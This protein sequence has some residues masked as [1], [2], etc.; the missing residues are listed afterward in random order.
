M[1]A[2]VYY[3]ALD[4]FKFKFTFAFYR[5]CRGI[6]MP[7]WPVNIRCLDKS[8]NQSMGRLSTSTRVIT[9]VTPVCP[10]S[11]SCGSSSNQAFSS[12][13]VE[14]HEYTMIIDFNS[15]TLKKFLTNGCCWVRVETSQ[16]AR[17]GAI[18]TGPSGTMYTYADINICRAPLNTSPQFDKEPIAYLCCNQPARFTMGGGDYVDGDHCEYSWANPMRGYNQNTSYSSKYSYREPFQ[19]HYPGSLK[20]PYSNPVAS[21]PVG[22]FLDS[23]SG[24][25]VFTPTKCDEVTVAV[26]EIREYRTNSSG[27]RELIGRTRRDM[28]FEITQCPANAPPR[29]VGKTTHTFTPSVCDSI[30]TFYIKTEDKPVSS[31]KKDTVSVSILKAPPGTTIELVDSTSRTPEVKVTWKP[32]KSD[33]VKRNEVQFVLKAK[34]QACPYFA[35]T[36]KTFRLIL[37]EDTVTTKVRIKAFKDGDKDCVLDSGETGIEGRNIQGRLVSQSSSPVLKYK[38]DTSGLMELCTNKGKYRVT[39]FPHPY[40]YDLCSDT[41][42]TAEVDSTHFV[43]FG[44]EELPNTVN[45]KVFY[46]DSSN[47]KADSI[48][49]GLKWTLVKATPGPYYG[50]SDYNGNYWINL[51]NGTF[52]LNPSKEW[53]RNTCKSE[54]K[55][56]LKND[57]V[58]KNANLFVKQDTGN[59]KLRIDCPHFVRTNGKTLVDLVAINQGPDTLKDVKAYMYVRS[60]LDGSNFYNFTKEN[61][62]LFSISGDIPPHSVI[63]GRL[64]INLSSQKFSSGDKFTIMGAVKSTHSLLENIDN[65]DDTTSRKIEV[66]GSYDPNIKVTIQD[67]LITPFDSILDY[68]IHFQNTGTAPAYYVE[69][70]DTLPDELDLGELNIE[71]ASH[72]PVHP[73]LRDNKLFFIFDEIV[74]P[75][76]SSDEEGSKGYVNFTINQKKGFDRDTSIR[77]SASI[78]FDLNEPVKTNTW[79]NTVKSPITMKSV[80]APEYCPN[81]TVHVGFYTRFVPSSSNRWKVWLSDATGSFNTPMLLLDTAMVDTTGFLPVSLP[82]NLSAGANYRFMMT[83]SHYLATTFIDNESNTFE[84]HNRFRDTLVQHSNALC[85]GGKATIELKNKSANKFRLFVNNVAVDSNGIGKWIDYSVSTGDEIYVELSDNGKCPEFS[86]TAVFS[87]YPSPNAGMQLDS[88]YCGTNTISLV[89]TTKSID[90]IA[91]Y[92]ILWGDGQSTTNSSISSESHTFSNYG[93]YTVE[94]K[95]ETENGCR[96]SIDQKVTVGPDPQISVSFPSQICESD[97]VQLIHSSSIASGTIDSVKWLVGNNVSPDQSWQKL[98]DGQHDISLFILSDLGCGDTIN[99]SIDA[100]E[101]PLALIDLNII[102]ACVHK[103]KVEMDL[104]ESNSKYAISNQNWDYDIGTSTSSNLISATF[105]GSGT[106]TISLEVEDV[107]GCLDTDTQEVTIIDYLPSDFELNSPEQCLN[108]NVFIPINFDDGATLSGA[109]HQ[110]EL[111]GSVVSTTDFNHSF[112]N[113]GTHTI[114]HYTSVNGD[115]F[116]TTQLTVN[117]MPNPNVDFT[118]APICEGEEATFTNQADNSGIVIN[119][120]LWDLEVNQ[121]DYTSEQSIVT[122]TFNNSGTYTI[123]QVKGSNGCYDTLSQSLTVFPNPIVE[124]GYT[125]GETGLEIIFQNKSSGGGQSTWD[126]GDGTGTQNVNG[127]TVTHTYENTGKYTVKLVEVSPDG[128]SDSINVLV[129]AIGEVVFIVPNAYT[130]NNDGINDEF[131]IVDPDLIESLTIKLYN[132][133]GAMVHEGI[134]KNEPLSGTDLPT[135]LYVYEI[136][137]VDIN[138]MKH[139]LQGDLRVVR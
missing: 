33:S 7:T 2:D 109:T 38:T 136:V 130:P 31:S 122:E 123:T 128:C 63:Y 53:H 17:N 107:N 134:D 138:G 139:Y 76:S 108:E 56:T 110:W 73:I 32:D 50:I 3:E 82:E 127:S 52:T 135:G 30:A 91:L 58:I 68:T 80:Y 70:R 94:L 83:G 67:S 81:D 39:M 59:L 115:C 88:L 87:F 84:V 15:S 45:G 71:S 4:S 125:T 124:V 47:C 34:D 5:D 16:N 46:D 44:S 9:D 105:P 100:F 61:D 102:N 48:D 126:F 43:S 57:T 14:R 13:G 69:I 35:V 131:H 103:N 54:L 118:L 93:N 112:G 49:K 6:A 132:R 25:F 96:D 64:Y 101:N 18:T 72:Y 77:N 27:K 65:T 40:Y 60:D 98:S 21:P 129:D 114:L 97:S 133:W 92:E 66:R 24:D 8:V 106:Y 23:L 117:V 137:L 55:V 26:L 12:K 95:V 29:F 22:L 62:S 79:V 121:Q 74:L 89:D 51:P 90:A 116:D 78:Y 28:Q 86:D 104:D 111:D 20:W 37:L 85:S 1:G 75:D 10:T 41:T 19:V 113:V 11:S 42:F 119:E 120:D 36:K 99:Q